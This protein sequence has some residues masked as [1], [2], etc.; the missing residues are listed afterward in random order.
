MLRSGALDGESTILHAPP[1][2]RAEREKDIAEY[3][4]QIMY[5]RRYY[6]EEFEY[7]CA[8]KR[9]RMAG[10]RGAAI[11]GMGALHGAQARTPYIVV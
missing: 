10:D 11:A 4:Q 5:S 2:E 9:S 8:A 6:D 7:R 3:A 1:K